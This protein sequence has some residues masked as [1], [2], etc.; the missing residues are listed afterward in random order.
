[1]AF[2]RNLQKFI[3]S[4]TRKRKHYPISRQCD[5]RKVSCREGYQ[6]NVSIIWLPVPS[7][8]IARLDTITSYVISRK[9]NLLH[10]V[11]R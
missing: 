1:M 5:I 8:L 9:L 3:N 10:H 4:S 2:S 7:R 11:S 6:R